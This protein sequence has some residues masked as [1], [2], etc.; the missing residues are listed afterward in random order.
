MDTRQLSTGNLRAFAARLCSLLPEAADLIA[1]EF[2]TLLEGNRTYEREKKARQRSQDN[3]PGTRSPSFKENIKKG[4]VDILDYEPSELD[5]AAARHAVGEAGVAAALAE[6]RDHHADSGPQQWSWLF[7]G[8]CSR[9]PAL[10]AARARRM[11]QG[12]AS[13]APVKVECAFLLI[14]SPEWI[15]AGSPR[16]LGAYDDRTRPGC[17]IKIAA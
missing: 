15:A 8:W 14:G 7:R 5:L 2:E 1:A 11:G 17:W 3:V 10:L 13:K 12:R 6:F 9:R 4:A 16:W